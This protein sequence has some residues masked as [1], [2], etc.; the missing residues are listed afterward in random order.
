MGT[1][2]F[3]KDIDFLKNS[4]YPL[5][6]GA[7][8]FCLDWLVEDKD[9]KLIHLSVNFTGEQVTLQIRISWGNFIWWNSRSGND[10]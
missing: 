1:L 9:G 6:K 7:A 2:Y 3:T 4:G 8:Q 10:T 5:R